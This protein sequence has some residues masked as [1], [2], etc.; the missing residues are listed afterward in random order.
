MH[1]TV[2]AHFSM[3]MKISLVYALSNTI[4]SMP[5]VKLKECIEECTGVPTHQQRLTI[6]DTIVEDWDE[7]DRMMFIGDYPNIQHGSLLYLI[8]LDGG[9][10]MTI[11][12]FMYKL[13]L[14]KKKS[15]LNW[16]ES[17]NELSGEEYRYQTRHFYVNSVKVR[18]HSCS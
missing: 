12:C 4:Q 13:C 3:S 7:E 5:I 10:R 8:Q 2:Y 18:I 9:Y 15:L 6:G 17:P 16:F 14:I 1:Q 11:Q